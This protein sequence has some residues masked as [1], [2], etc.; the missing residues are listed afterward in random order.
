MMLRTTLLLRT[1]KIMATENKVILWHSIKMSLFDVLENKFLF[2]SRYVMI[3]A[4]PCN[5][6]NTFILRV[7]SIVTLLK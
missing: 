1:I 7:V 6:I 5:K 2:I 4:S 3:Q